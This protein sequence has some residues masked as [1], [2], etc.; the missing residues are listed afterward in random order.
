LAF[1]FKQ[2]QTKQWLA[3]FLLMLVGIGLRIFFFSGL[4]GSDDL[5]YSKNANS[6]ITGELKPAASPLY[7]RIGH[8]AMTGFFFLVFGINE[9]ALALLPFLASV[10]QMLLAWWM[11]ANLKLQKAGLFAVGLLAIMPWDVVFATRGYPD[12]PSSALFAAFV[13]LMFVGIYGDKKRR[14]AMSFFAGFCLG[15]AYLVKE[16]SLVSMFYWAPALLV[17]LFTNKLVRLGT[18]ALCGA[19]A[20]LI[21]ILESIGYQILT[22]DFLFRFHGVDIGY[23]RSTW[24]GTGLY[25][26]M[27]HRVFIDGPRALFL[28]TVFLQS[29]ALAVVFFVFLGW[30]EKRLRPVFGWLLFSLLFFIAGTSSVSEFNPLPLFR[31]YMLIM[32]FPAAILIG[33]SMDQGLKRLKEPDGAKRWWGVLAMSAIVIGAGAWNRPFILH[34]LA[35][36]LFFIAAF[37]VFWKKRALFLLPLGLGFSLLVITGLQGAYPITK[38]NAWAEK[39]LFRVIEKTDEPVYSDIRTTGIL[40]FFDGYTRTTR[41]LDIAKAKQKEVRGCFVALNEGRVSFM[42][43]NYDYRMPDWIRHGP[44]PGY[45]L[46]GRFGPKEPGKNIYLF[47]AP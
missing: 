44:P 19:G 14:P 34:Q 29:F 39:E 32:A 16:M 41:F 13:A 31:R 6:L 35:G 21:F 42:E 26:D 46:I 40:Q 45:K 22:G 1:S 3:L 47:F 27:I 11:L 17:M 36:A 24:S 28:D 8:I 10:A 4:V 30:R 7:N 18:L 15:W 37:L 12:L 43:S 33:V 5:A 25:Q 38:H 23:N 9:I 2:N 20:L